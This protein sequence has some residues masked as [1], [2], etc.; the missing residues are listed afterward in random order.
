[1]DGPVEFGREHCCSGRVHFA[2][3]DAEGQI[4]SYMA[5]RAEMNMDEDVAPYVY[6]RTEAMTVSGKSVAISC[7]QPENP[8]K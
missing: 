6:A 7:A 5:E 2:G 1:M 4:R 8:R 3:D